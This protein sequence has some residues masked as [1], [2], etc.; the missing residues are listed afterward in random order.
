MSK[1]LPLIS[2]KIFTPVNTRCI[3]M[4]AIPNL[5][6]RLARYAQVITETQNAYAKSIVV[7]VLPQEYTNG[8][9]LLDEDKLDNRQL[10]TIG[11][12][13]PFDGNDLAGDFAY[14]RSGNDS[15]NIGAFHLI[16]APGLFSVGTSRLAP[17]NVSFPDAIMFTIFLVVV[18]ATGGMSAI[19]MFGSS[20]A[21]VFLGEGDFIVL[22][23]DTNFNSQNPVV[24]DESSE[25][26][27]TR[28]S[29]NSDYV[30]PQITP[31]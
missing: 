25:I 6:A 31:P 13:G 28:L 8:A 12:Y 23:Y 20:T 24:A 7:P 30:A 14:E 16:G 15:Q 22:V 9:I 10:I 27:I 18:R 21:Q 1:P 4:S 26:F 3:D 29:R 11:N 2:S 17:T 5:E 19:P